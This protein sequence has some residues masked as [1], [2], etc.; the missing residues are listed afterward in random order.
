MQVV[1]G[2]SIVDKRLA[3]IFVSHIANAIKSRSFSTGPVPLRITA[4][5]SN[6]KGGMSAP[7]AF[8]AGGSAS[9]SQ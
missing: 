7:V 5:N 1:R 2:A 9:R 4:I 6:G 8:V 3:Y